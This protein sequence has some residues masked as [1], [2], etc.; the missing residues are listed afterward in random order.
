MV[1]AILVVMPE[2]PLNV[3]G[4][5]DRQ[6]L[7]KPQETLAQ[8][9]REPATEQERL[10]CRAMANLLGMERVG[11]DDDFFALGGD[12][13]SAMGLGTALRRNGYLLRPREIFAL[14]TPRAHG[15]GDAA[16]GRRLSGLT[17]RA[18]RPDRRAADP[19][20]VRPETG[21]MH[22]RFAHGV[23]LRVPAELQPE[24]LRDALDQLRAAHPALGA[25]IRDGRLVVEEAASAE[26]MQVQAV[27]GE[28]EPAAEQAFDAALEHLDPAA[29]AMMQAIL[30]QRDGQS[31][32][33]VLAIHH[34]VVDGVSW[35]ILLEELRQVA[36]SAMQGA[37]DHAAAG[38]NLA[39]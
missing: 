7:P 2:L 17:Q 20:L 25:R 24:Q 32:G 12:S 28:L 3:N 23:F 27:S 8:S 16:A 5:I 33:L 37:A 26:F 22:R 13:I 15:A 36:D 38:R 29:G 19:A 14:H 30:L 39:L 1:P 34:L 4:K 31:L 10:I 6:A 11:A 18:A 21:D 9:I 35:R